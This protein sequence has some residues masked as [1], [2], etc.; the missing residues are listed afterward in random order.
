MSHHCA[1]SIDA[2]RDE[3]LQ[4]AQI[5]PSE[6]LDAPMKP[7]L[8]ADTLRADRTRFQIRPVVAAA[9]TNAKNSQLEGQIACAA[10]KPEQVP[11]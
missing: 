3:K 11:P 4:Q 2:K 6:D 5:L 9:A 8:D 10:G 1:H 7:S